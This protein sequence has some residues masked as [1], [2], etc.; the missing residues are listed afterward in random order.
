M[1][2]K[3][4]FG[5]LELKITEVRKIWKKMIVKRLGSLIE[6]FSFKN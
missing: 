1:R 3:K 2:R 6:E 5:S 4:E